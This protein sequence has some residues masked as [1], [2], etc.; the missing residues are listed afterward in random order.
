MKARHVMLDLETLATS[1]DA[2]ILSIGAAAFDPHLG[3]TSLYH[4]ILD[5]AEQKT[6]AI[7]ASTVMWWMDKDDAARAI[8]KQEKETV[9]D[10]LG[11]FTKFV[12]TSSVGAKEVQM[13]GNGSDF[14]NVLL[15]NLY[16]WADMD[17]FLPWSPF[18]GRC[19]RT[20]KNLCPDYKRISEGVKRV[21]RHSAVDDARWQAEVALEL[22][23]AMGIK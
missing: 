3:I 6:R 18:N 21:T 17:S 14:D 23:T 13:W 7:S 9:P 5:I 4:S 19:F 2:V 1:P 22:F 8:F 10:A 15:T 16:H 12:G 20:L 11:G